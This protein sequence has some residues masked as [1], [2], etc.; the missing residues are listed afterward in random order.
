MHYGEAMK[1][2]N[3]TPLETQIWKSKIC[4]TAILTYLLER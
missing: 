3:A 4:K 1:V 2:K